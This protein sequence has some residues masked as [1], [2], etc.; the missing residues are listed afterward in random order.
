MTGDRA[1]KSPEPA[2][3]GNFPGPLAAAQG[4]AQTADG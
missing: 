2:L 4:G 1:E 3:P